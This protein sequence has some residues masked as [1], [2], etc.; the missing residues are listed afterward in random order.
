ML[1][2]YLNR[3]KPF[4]VLVFLFIAVMF[5]VLFSV[6]IDKKSNSKLLV[7]IYKNQEKNLESVISSI[8]T[9]TIHKNILLENIATLYKSKGQDGLQSNDVLVSTPLVIYDTKGAYLYNSTHLNTIPHHYDLVPDRIQFRIAKINNEGLLFF[10]LMVDQLIYTT[11]I[12]IEQLFERELHK[13][14]QYV[15]YNTAS[16]VMYASEYSDILTQ[17]DQLVADQNSSVESGKSGLLI[18]ILPVNSELHVGVYA[19]I[20]AYFSNLHDYR[21]GKLGFTGLFFGISILILLVLVK[22]YI[23]RFS[24]E[25]EKYEKLFFLEQEKFQSI[26]EAIGEGVALI[27]IEHNLIWC[28]DFIKDST[29]I[30]KMGKCYEILANKPSPCRGCKFDEV[31]TDRKICHMNYSNY[32][33]NRE[34]HYEVVLSPLMDENG[35]VVA[36]VDL[37]RDVTE[38]VE[39]NKKILQSEK[40]SALGLLAG[41]I[42]HEINN[43]LVGILNFAQLLSKKLPAGSSESKLAE[44]IV[45]AGTETKKIVQ[46]L[47]TYARQSV[48]KKEQ[49]DICESINFAVKILNS[50]IKAKHIQIDVLGESTYMVSANKGKMHQVFLNL[51]SNSLDASTDHG[52]ITI[53]LTDNEN[54]K[55]I[56]IRDNGEGIEQGVLDRIFDPFFTTKEVGK[57]TGLGLSIIAGIINEHGWTI[58]AN[59]VVGEFT[60]FTINITSPEDGEM[61]EP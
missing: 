40:L 12:P 14:Q 32:I 21:A 4:E 22:Y 11:Y 48:D 6:F 50:R 58:T 25:K 36:V 1:S 5:L 24:F 61:N 49:Y 2:R 37:I 19:P 28:N 20:S 43:P 26:V 47:L 42:A 17:M 7:F 52:I 54:G 51:L 41:G 55:Q 39:L 46:N 27:D 56:E 33:N 59:S 18:S 53:R 29:P 13:F 9:E 57:G 45:E 16:K 3:L 35:T 10:Y 30:D 60:A 31:I 34:G 8:E 23:T 44:T 15:V 38:S